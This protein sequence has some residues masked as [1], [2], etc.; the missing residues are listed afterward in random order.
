MLLLRRAAQGAW[1]ARVAAAARSA[2][3]CSAARPAPFSAAAAARAPPLCARG[4]HSAARAEP[5][6][7]SG[8]PR[9]EAS[10]G[11]HGLLAGVPADGAFYSQHLPDL[12]A[13]GALVTRH[14]LL[15]AAAQADAEARGLS[16][17][18]YVADVGRAAVAFVVSNELV[19]RAATVD[20]LCKLAGADEGTLVLLVGAKD[21][22]KSLIV[23]TLPDLLKPLRR[24]VVVLSARV[25]G[26]DLARGIINGI[27]PDATM[28]SEFVKQLTKMAPPIAAG[29]LSF[30]VKAAFE[31]L[32]SD[33]GVSAEAASAAAS[34][35]GASAAS[36]FTTPSKAPAEYELEELVAVL[37]AYIAACATQGDFPVLVI[38][39]AN[40][41]LPSPRP[42]KAP[43]D[44]R[45]EPPLTPDEA[46]V[47]LRTLAA[48]SLLTLLSK[49]S[50]R[51]NVLLAASEHAEPFRL[52][53]L[54]YS[55]AHMTK[56]VVASEVPPAEMRAMLVD[57]WRCGPAL[58]EGLL[59]VYGGHVLRAKNA[60]SD[61][62]RE[63]AGFKAIS[64]FTPDAIRG[65]LACLQAARS[66]DQ[67]MGGL[68]G[69]LHELAERGFAA[70]DDDTDPRA[71]L[72]SHFNVGGVVLTSTFA[73]GVPPAAWVSGD[74][75]VLA[76]SSQCM[77]LLLASKLKPD[78]P[79]VSGSRTSAP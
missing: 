47:R 69:V 5:P 39:E 19:D 42:R 34:A 6:P 4:A 10:L 32:P 38:D 77:R 78:T 29:I 13:A 12:R 3:L 14:G 54:G 61:L 71:A 7:A 58:A 49:E 36:A 59:A 53:E 64:A 63:K 22:G 51:L 28:F 26:P 35:A 43:G 41:A 55:T 72:V 70:I 24:R 50:K 73:P 56:V 25:T 45:P 68:E 2:A 33:L 21:V 11:E 79:S 31:A 16:C 76:A 46:R 60:L 17:D 66:S 40:L 65:A 37:G 15:W 57:K 75:V 74:S 23:R 9:A 27:K 48:L 30:A 18:E 44:T 67:S 62:A 8:A 1:G 52:A 20:A